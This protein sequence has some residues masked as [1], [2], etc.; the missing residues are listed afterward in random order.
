MNL[1]KKPVKIDKI[2]NKNKLK[3]AQILEKV[4]ER[5]K[6]QKFWLKKNRELKRKAKKLKNEKKEKEMW[7]QLNELNNDFAK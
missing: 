5:E 4:K 3:V 2:G 7:G 1:D 6:K